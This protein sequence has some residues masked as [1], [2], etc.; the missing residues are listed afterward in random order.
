MPNLWTKATQKIAEAFSGP[1][2]RDTEF[3]SKLEE[4]KAIEKGVAS[5]RLVFQNF[6]NSTSG[7]RNICRDLIISIKQV[8]E[9]NSHFSPVCNDIL[10]AHV[11]LELL[12][13]NFFK[14]VEKIHSRSSEWPVLFS[15]AKSQIQKRI[16]VRKNYDHYDEKLEKIYKSKQEKLKKGT[17]ESAKDLEF[18]KRNEEKYKKATEDYVKI[19][20]DAYYTIQTILNKRYELINPVLSDFIAEEEKFYE[21]SSNVFKKLEN[22]SQRFKSISMTFPKIANTYDACKYIRGGEIIQKDKS[23]NPYQPDDNFRIDNVKNRSF[24]SIP[25]RKQVEED[26]NKKI[27]KQIVTSNI[28]E[29]V[30][31]NLTLTPNTSFNN[32]PNP[33]ININVLKSDVVYKDFSQFED[34]FSRRVSNTISTTNHYNNPGINNKCNNDINNFINN[35]FGAFDS[36]AN[37]N[38]NNNLN[39][40]KPIIQNLGKNTNFK[41]S[42]EA[43]QSLVI[44]NLKNNTHNSQL[45]LDPFQLNNEFKNFGIN[46][47][48]TNNVNTNVN[49]LT[50]N[51][52]ASL[53][54]NSNYN[55]I[56]NPNYGNTFTPTNRPSNFNNFNKNPLF[57]NN[58]SH[59]GYSNP[60][61]EINNQANNL[62][63]SYGIRNGNIQGN[64]N[65][66]LINAAPDAYK[67]TKDTKGGKNDLFKDFF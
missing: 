16:D 32:K 45:N 65:N 59:N 29:N 23:L 17:Q 15:Q 57:N 18:L 56:N 13:E 11:D 28:S 21:K 9:K 4:M 26:T 51:N 35:D 37:V 67:A 7:F 60:N 54:M 22:I 55:I 44:D 6:L 30:N 40:N 46:P 49:N 8:Y 25:T 3:E 42:N 63:I 10:E 50:N 34:Q 24:S 14:N 47:I 43:R 12:Y 61:Q 48:P 41:N 27:S 31:N 33:N 53:S 38:H 2:T 1:R 64:Q 20:E 36:F 5:L 19:S 62:N 52:R 58:S 39:Q 66:N